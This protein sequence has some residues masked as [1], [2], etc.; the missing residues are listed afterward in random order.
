M[1]RPE[2][3]LY[4]ALGLADPAAMDAL[5]AEHPALLHGA[6]PRL[7]PLELAAHEG[8]L[9][10]VRLLLKRG[11]DVHAGQEAALR[12]AARLN[13]A[14]VCELLVERG[15][16][17]N[18]YREGYGPILR[19]AC[20]FHA[21][22]AVRLL[23]ARGADAIGQLAEGDAHPCRLLNTNLGLALGTAHRTDRLHAL[24]EALISAG[25]EVGDTAMMAIH[26]GRL[27]LL[28]QHLDRNPFLLHARFPELD[29]GPHTSIPFPGGTLLHLCAEFGEV[30]AARLLLARGA[31]VNAPAETGPGGRGG[32]TP[33]FHAV[34]S[35]ENFCYP[36]LELLIE[37]GADLAARARLPVGTEVREV[38]PL[39][40]ALLGGEECFTPEIELLRRH[41][42]EA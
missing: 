18:A 19:N 40:L 6:D 1:E 23:L 25:A 33:I 7:S 34:T 10:M 14:A 37:H 11:A 21:L 20:E 28:E 12:R 41:G 26:R 32:R 9:E 31:D 24:V 17:V 39:G 22:E 16:N 42:G 36:M 35:W 30:E 13:H 2:T 29:Y 27:D 15:A 38:T 5:L 3:R 8:Q 4:R